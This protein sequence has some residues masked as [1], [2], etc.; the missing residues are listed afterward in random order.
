MK[1]IEYQV[2]GSD[3]T[4]VG[5][6][7][8]SRGCEEQRDPVIPKLREKS[9]DLTATFVSRLTQLEQGMGAVDA[10]I[11]N[12]DQQVEGLEADIAE[13]HEEVRE[14]LTKL[15]ESNQVDLPALKD[16]FMAEVARLRDFH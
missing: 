10:H 1:T 8:H 6:S 14:A 15:R 9:K 7:Q 2:T 5:S 13:T 11:E 4:N 16:K 12:L 3:T